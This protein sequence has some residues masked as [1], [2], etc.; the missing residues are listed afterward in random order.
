MQTNPLA[1]FFRQPAIYMRL[2]S[3]GRGWPRDAIDLPQSQELPVLPMTAMDEITYRTP[4]ALFNGEATV[5]VIQSCVPAIKDAWACPSTD[6]DAILTSIRIATYGHDMDMDSNCP[7]CEHENNFAVDLRRVLDQ[8]RSADF[9][10]PLTVGDM[11]IYFRPLN[12]RQMTDNNM[13]Q[14]EQQK[15]LQLLNDA[16]DRTEEQKVEVVNQMMKNLVAL[17]VKAMSHSVAEIRLPD[18]IV[19]DHDFIEE[20]LNNCD[21]AVFAQIRDHAID[22]KESTELQPLSVTCNN[23]SHQYEQMLTLDM[24][25]FFGSAS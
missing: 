16:E 23:C 4:D 6:L 13:L 1:R 20:F 19:N 17:T 14:F 2:P 10:R 5:Q 7:K 11:T 22:L 15:A 18:A 9:T 8:F 24:A 3:G 21:R 25:R 12:Y